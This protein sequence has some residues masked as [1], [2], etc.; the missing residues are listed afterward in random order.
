MGYNRQFPRARLRLC[1]NHYS[2][3]PGL[4]TNSTAFRSSTVIATFKIDRTTNFMSL[5]YDSEPQESLMNDQST[6][7]HVLEVQKGKESGNA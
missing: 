5:S 4:N 2:V 7:S 6:E 1:R 3:Q